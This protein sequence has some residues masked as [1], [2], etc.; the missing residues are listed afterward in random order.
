MSHSGDNTPKAP[1]SAEIREA[2]AFGNK[3]KIT[4]LSAQI[5]L[6]ELDDPQYQGV[7]VH[8]EDYDPVELGLD[9][10]AYVLFDLEELISEERAKEIENGGELNQSELEGLKNWAIAERSDNSDG[11][12]ATLWFAKIVDDTGSVTVV[13]HQYEDGERQFDGF[14]EDDEKYL[15][16]LEENQVILIDDL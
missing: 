13:F 11:A 2:L 10:V 9:H 4:A 1:K 7:E 16:M 14:V 15:K 6:Y 5:D 12:W 8:K 3:K